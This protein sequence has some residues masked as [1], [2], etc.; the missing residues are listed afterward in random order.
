MGFFSWNCKGCGHPM[1]SEY[2]SNEGNKWMEQVVVIEG[3]GSILTG[4]YDGYGNV[5][6]RAIDWSEEHECYHRAC[7]EKAGK[8]IDYTEASQSSEDQGYF[9]DD[10]DHDMKEPKQRSTK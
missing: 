6:D 8:P 7:W 3:E 10:G 1:L 5:N 2:S 9:F 4:E